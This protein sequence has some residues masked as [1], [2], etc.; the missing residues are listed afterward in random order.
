[1][2]KYREAGPIVEAGQYRDARMGQS[3]NEW[4]KSFPQGVCFKGCDGCQYP[5]VHWST[6]VIQVKDGDWVIV[7]NGGNV[8]LCEPNRFENTYQKVEE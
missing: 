4:I 1:M 5:H 2:A 8:A 7:D 3:T 6:S